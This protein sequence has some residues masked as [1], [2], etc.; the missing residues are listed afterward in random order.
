MIV[1]EVG[2]T[3]TGSANSF[4]PPTVTIASSGLKPSTCSA[5]RCRKSSGI[6]NGKYAFG[7]PLALMRSSSARCRSSQ[8]PYAQGRMTIVPRTG[9]FSASS[10][11]ATTS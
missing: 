6:S 5:S 8:M 1:S 4:P 7:A 11:L 2:R 10:A 3:T 9:P